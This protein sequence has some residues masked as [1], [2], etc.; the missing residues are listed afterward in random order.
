[1]GSPPPALPHATE[2]PPYEY[3]TVMYAFIEGVCTNCNDR[4][5][6]QE[7]I[8]C[9][10]EYIFLK[11]SC[12]IL[13]IT[14]YCSHLG[15]GTQRINRFTAFILCFFI[16]FLY[17]RLGRISEAEKPVCIQVFSAGIEFQAKNRVIWSFKF[18]CLNRHC[19][20]CSVSKITIMA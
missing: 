17:Y 2:A 10:W 4:G 9:S 1:M 6:Q 8:L 12:I 11:F 3:G 5:R 16:F 18:K 19:K 7:S 14:R 13:V 20:R 15:S